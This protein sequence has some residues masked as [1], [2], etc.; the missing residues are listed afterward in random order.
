MVNITTRLTTQKIVLIW[1]T[2]I[3]RQ[4]RGKNEKKINI[5]ETKK[6]TKSNRSKQILRKIILRSHTKIVWS[7]VPPPP[8]G[9]LDD[10]LWIIPVAIS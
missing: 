9:P 8:S 6:A 5:T 7:R 4:V 2:Q 1:N 3:L 10:N